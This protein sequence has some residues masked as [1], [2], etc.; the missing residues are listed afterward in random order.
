MQAD[1]N[2]LFH[3]DSLRK[4]KPDEFGNSEIAFNEAHDAEH[5]YYAKHYKDLYAP[6]LRY[7]DTLDEN[8]LVLFDRIDVGQNLSEYAKQTMKTKDVAYIDGSVPVDDREKIRAKLESSGNNIL[9]AEIA[10]FSTGVNVKR[11]NH[12]TFACNTKSFSRV[13][14]AIGRTLRLH[15]LKSEAHLIDCHFNFKYATRHFDERLKIYKTSYSKTP[16]EFMTFEI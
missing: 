4:Y 3:V 6:V 13:L 12:I 2:I 14:Q 15:S 7:L 10:V 5:E 1:R 11:L 9:F 8:I 16:D